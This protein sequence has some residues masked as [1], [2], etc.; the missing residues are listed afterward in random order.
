[1][2]NLRETVTD[3]DN[4]VATIGDEDKVLETVINGIEYKPLRD[5]LLKPL[6]AKLIKKIIK[7]PIPT[8]EMDET[9]GAMKYDVKE[10]EKEMEADFREGVVLRL[11]IDYEGPIQ[12]GDIV[13][14][15]KNSAAYF[16]LFKDS[17]I[18]HPQAVMFKKIK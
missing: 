6:E 10:E 8:G 15:H 16:D 9:S 4:V 18:I 7:T 13:V 11:P 3:V 5:I 14:F 2:S 17:M 12:V 1:M